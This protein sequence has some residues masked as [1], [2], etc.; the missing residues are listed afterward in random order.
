MSYHGQIA[1]EFGNATVLFAHCGQRIPAEMQVEFELLRL[2]DRQPNRNWIDAL[3]RRLA[4]AAKPRP[5]SVLRV[6]PN[7]ERKVTEVLTEAGLSVYHPRERYRPA[8][9]WRSRTRPLMPGY[10]FFDLADDDALDTARANHAVIDV[11][12]KDGKP[13][14]V[15]AIEVGLM[16]LAEWAGAFDTT[17]TSPPPLRDKRRGRRPPRRK[18]KQGEAAR[19]TDGPLAGF[20]AQIKSADRADRIEAFVTIFGR[21]TEVTMDEEM[22]EAMA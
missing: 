21:V 22:L 14:K 11:M 6:K 7:M 10:L 19:V 16:V 9:T 18:W 17:W 13:L 1:G 8:R 15:P 3:Q 4:L 20:L 2:F 12:C 5:W